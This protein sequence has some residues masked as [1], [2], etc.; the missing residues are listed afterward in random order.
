MSFKW[1]CHMR[2]HGYLSKGS[3]DTTIIFMLFLQLAFWSTT[4]IS[5]VSPVYLDHE[6]KTHNPGMVELRVRRRLC[7]W[8][9]HEA[10]IATLE[11]QFLPFFLW[12][13]KTM[14]CEP[15]SWKRSV[16]LTP[17]DHSSSHS[18]F[19]L[20]KITSHGISR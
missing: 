4:L 5:G 8:S 20:F 17:D 15:V 1:S 13:D 19:Q 6:D 12:K 3:D 14:S 9:F 10:A 11:C 7:F 18:T 16:L 2:M